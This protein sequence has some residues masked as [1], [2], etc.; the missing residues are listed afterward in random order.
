MRINLNSVMD[1]RYN[2]PIGSYV[3]YPLSKNLYA[4]G[5]GKLNYIDSISNDVYFLNS[6]K[7]HPQNGF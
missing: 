1:H 4:A 5:I 3:V 6:I 7:I 2:D